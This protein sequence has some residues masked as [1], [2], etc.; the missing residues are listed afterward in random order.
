MEATLNI[1]HEFFKNVGG[2]LNIQNKSLFEIQPKNLTPV[3]YD[4]NRLH[5]NVHTNMPEL[6]RK[7]IQSRPAIP[8]KDDFW[9]NNDKEN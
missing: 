6:L 7:E 9:G 5:F 1:T 8:P 2:Y 3:E 4:F